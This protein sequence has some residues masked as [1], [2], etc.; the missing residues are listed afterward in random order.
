MLLTHSK[1]TSYVRSVTFLTFYIADNQLFSNSETLA[2]YNAK[3]MDLFPCSGLQFGIEG[4]VQQSI[5]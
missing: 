3:I 2:S 1:L 4:T 5:G